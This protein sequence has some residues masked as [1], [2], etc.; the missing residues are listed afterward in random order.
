MTTEAKPYKNT[1][2]L[3]VARFDMQANLTVN[4]PQRPPL[5]SGLRLGAAAR[6]LKA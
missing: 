3:S 4:E 2:N 6:T 5:W 1:L